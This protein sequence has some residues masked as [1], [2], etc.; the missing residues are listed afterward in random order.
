MAALAYAFDGSG[1]NATLGD[2]V[3]YDGNASGAQ[4]AFTTLAQFGWKLV[5]EGVTTLDEVD[6]VAGQG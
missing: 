4:L 5:A 6:R 2:A 3:A 1:G